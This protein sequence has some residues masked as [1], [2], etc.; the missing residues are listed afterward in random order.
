[1]AGTRGTRR[2]TSIEK[3]ELGLIDRAAPWFAHPVVK[4]VGTIGKIGDQPPLLALSGLVMAVGLL[5]RDVRL[6]RAGARMTL[7]HVL[8][9]AAKT[10]GKDN[11]DRTRPRERARRGYSAELGQ[12][13]DPAMRSFPSG[14]TAGA[15]AVG[16]AI[17]REYPRHALAAQAAAGVIGVVQV[18]RRA[19]Y[20]TD[21][22]AGAIVGI[23]AEALVA[24]AI[25]LVWRLSPP[26]T[27]DRA[28]V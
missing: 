11:V 27:P 20:P 5:R 4:A 1:M 6:A 3:A 9:T 12:S 22:V 8:A 19:H 14:H 16:R 17:A 28:A 2:A 24:G 21:V 15:V 26:R 13:D 7:A 23:A 25:A 10:V 18:P